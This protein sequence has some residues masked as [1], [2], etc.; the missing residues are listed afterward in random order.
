M[1]SLNKHRLGVERLNSI[2]LLAGDVTGDD[3]AN[4]WDM[5]EINRFRLGLIETL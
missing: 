4:F 3:S 5:I 1:L 2:Y